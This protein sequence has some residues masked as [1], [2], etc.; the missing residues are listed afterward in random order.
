MAKQSGPFYRDVISDINKGKILPVY[1]LAGNEPYFID[2]IEEKLREKV[3]Q[4][5]ERDFNET[6]LYGREVELR[7][8]IDAAEQ[9]PMMAAR[10]LVIVREAQDLNELYDLEFYLKEPTETTVLVLCMKGKTLDGRRQMTKMVKDI[11]VYF[12][13]PPI[14]DN[15][16]PSWISD[17]LKTLD[18]HIDDPEAT[19]LAEY[20]GT[21]L[22]KIAKEL[23]KL[24]LNVQK[25]EKVS[26]E[27]IEKY[28][29]ISK[30][31]NIFELQRNLAYRKLENVVRISRYFAANPKIHPIQM[32]IG[33]LYSYFT[34]IYMMHGLKGNSPA[35]IQSKAGIP[36]G[37]IYKEY[38][39]SAKVYD[40]KSVENVFDLLYQFDR[41]SK[42]LGGDRTDNA[43]LIRE[44]IYLIY[45]ASEPKTARVR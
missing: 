42:G 19:L 6:I 37:N 10:Q 32:I 39:Q 17:Y 8:V 31:Y 40:R 15:Q 9:Y 5:H 33:S 18:T 21:N 28:I 36:R 35:V 1:V 30:D 20:L 27:D 7:S 41:R 12:V 43:E 23:D 3:I 45:Y 34:K 44:L 24:T 14:Y 29:G 11:G 16:V 25:G 22:S 26:R 2:K 13:A 4:P 38:V